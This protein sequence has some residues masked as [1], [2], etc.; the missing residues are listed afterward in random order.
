MTRSGVREPRPVSWAGPKRYW[1]CTPPCHRRLVPAGSLPGQVRTVARIAQTNSR[2]W[3]PSS[4]WVR[5][6]RLSIY[7][8]LM[9]DAQLPKAASSPPPSSPAMDDAE[10]VAEGQRWEYQRTV[11]RSDDGNRIDRHMNALAA[12][13]WELVNA[14]TNQFLI[15]PG[16]A[17]GVFLPDV[18]SYFFWRR[19]SASSPRSTDR[20]ERSRK[21]GSPKPET[22]SAENQQKQR[23]PSRISHLDAL[24][25]S[26]RLSVDAAQAFISDGRVRDEH[27]EQIK[28]LKP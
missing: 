25:A 11:V 5:T 17:S 28:D 9:H 4:H 20:G 27:W 6:A 24:V 18:C 2:A 21:P 3:L 7:C 23:T 12:Q 15:P 1:R 19:P 13:G 26:G 14:S 8:R 16:S 22:E 10:P